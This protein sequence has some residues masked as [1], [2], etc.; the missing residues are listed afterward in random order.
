MSISKNAYV[1]VNKCAMINLKYITCTA[2]S[3]DKLYVGQF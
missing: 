2:I 3:D 1:S